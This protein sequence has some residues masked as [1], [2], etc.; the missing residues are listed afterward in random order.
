MKNATVVVT[1]AVAVV[2]VVGVSRVGRMASLGKGAVGAGVGYDAESKLTVTEA[3][4]LWLSLATQG[5]PMLKIELNVLLTLAP[6][7]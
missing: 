3:A 7:R 1:E 5:V 2:V 4:P 6:G